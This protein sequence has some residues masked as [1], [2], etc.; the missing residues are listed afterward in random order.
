MEI[1]ASGNII[2]ARQKTS[3]TEDRK[4]KKACKDFEAILVNQM[5][6]AMRK[7]VPEGG[8]FEKNPTKDIVESMYYRNL[9]DEVSSGKGMGIG[10]ALYEDM[11]EA[12]EWK[13]HIADF[14]QKFST[15]A[16]ENTATDV[17]KEIPINTDNID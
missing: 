5:F 15:P 6:E 14:D 10:D 4:L 13:T 3:E 12:L 1:N 7:T 8:L 11:K 2:A 17:L 9:S 16:E